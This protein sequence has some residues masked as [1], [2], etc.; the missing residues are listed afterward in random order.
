MLDWHKRGRPFWTLALT[1]VLLVSAGGVSIAQEAGPAE[2]APVPSASSE[3]A[4]TSPTAASPESAVGEDLLAEEASEEEVPALPDMGKTL[5][6]MVLFM[7]LLLGLLVAGAVVFQR[8]ARG[9]ITL[10]GPKRPLR[11]VDR[12]T[13]GPKT[14]LCL[15]NVCGRHLVLGISEKEISVLLEVPMPQEDGDNSDFPG[16]L[17]RVETERSAKPSE[18]D[19]D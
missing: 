18:K 2:S 12:L 13:L 8:W 11:V 3:T 5:L 4:D 9:R 16:M 10:G 7:L 6:R 1:A 17:A 15:V 19:R 14:G